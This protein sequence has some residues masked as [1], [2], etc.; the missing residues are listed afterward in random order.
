MS[1][2][3]H[4]LSKSNAQDAQI[5][6]EAEC[7]VDSGCIIRNELKCYVAALPFDAM[8]SELPRTLKRL[9]AYNSVLVWLMN[10]VRQMK[11]K[12][13]N[14]WKTTATATDDTKM[15]VFFPFSSWWQ[16]DTGMVPAHAFASFH[17]IFLAQP[18]A[19]IQI[20]FKLWRYWVVRRAMY[21]CV[22]MRQ[23]ACVRL[24]LSKLDSHLTRAWPSIPCKKGSLHSRI[25][26]QN[27]KPNTKRMRKGIPIVPKWSTGITS[28]SQLK[29][30]RLMSIN[31][32]MM[33]GREVLRLMQPCK[34]HTNYLRS[35]IA[36]TCDRF[37]S[38][39]V[40]TD[41]NRHASTGQ[42]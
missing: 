29:T 34:R 12:I 40:L 28:W 26:R 5:Q 23:S 38:V 31:L 15:C 6:S 36:S 9:H 11:R 7:A 8:E 17:S 27:A 21:V 32:L 4:F 18:F 33:C 14:N 3:F 35:H 19:E 41:M 42:V 22:R 13:Q 25:D 1:D 10:V 37:A 24:R 2:C 39:F 30:I 16:H 20:I